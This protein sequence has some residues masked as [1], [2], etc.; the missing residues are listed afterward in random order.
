MNKKINSDTI[1][2]IAMVCMLI[3]HIGIGIV[4]KIYYTMTDYNTAMALS[5][6]DNILRAVGRIA[7]PL[8]AY[9]LVKGF[10]YTKNRLKH[11]LNLIVFAI[12]SEVPF[13]LLGE[14][15]IW[16]PGH[17]NVIITLTLGTLMMWALEIVKENGIQN[18]ISNEKVRDFTYRIYALVLVTCVAS[19][20]LL[21]HT[22]YGARG[23]VTIAI[24]Y[25]LR[26]DKLRLLQLGPVLFI[27][28]I[29]FV[30]LITQG[31]MQATVRYCEFEIYAV[32]AFPIMYADTGLRNEKNGYL[33]KWF[34]YWF[35]PVHQLV[36]Y[37]ISLLIVR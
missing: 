15:T 35:Y 30:T 28:N 1:K 27:L 5:R 21:L 26:D 17:Q 18:S 25:M 3:D 9:M 4:E 19:F 12:I 20:A 14:G 8:F 7:Y 10:F 24:I 31:N 22:D 16:D 13:D 6:V 37:L 29:V 2:I 34:G 11:V 32:A 23:I 33:L 36:I